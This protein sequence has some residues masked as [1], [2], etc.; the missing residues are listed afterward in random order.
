LIDNKAPDTYDMNVDVLDYGLGNI[1]SVIRMI[2]KVGGTA[3]R[4]STPDEVRQADKLILPRG[5]PNRELIQLPGDIENGDYILATMNSIYWL[6][7]E[8]HQNA[9]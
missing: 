7:L 9:A 5:F 1:S 8:E 6:K 2:E 3:K 4:I